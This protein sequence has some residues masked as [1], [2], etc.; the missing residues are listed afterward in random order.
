MSTSGK[1]RI[2]VLHIGNIANY[3]YNIAKLLQTDQI[4]SDAISWDY[5]HINS[6]PIWEE[7]DFDASNAGDQFFPLLP[8][9]QDAGFDQPDWYWHGPRKLAMLGLIAANEGRRGLSQIIRRQCERHLRRIADPVYRAS[10]HSD[11]KAAA[12]LASDLLGG[13]GSPKTPRYA[14]RWL[15]T[16]RWGHPLASI[17][18]RIA[19]FGEARASRR[20]TIS[21]VSAS[22]TERADALLERFK[23]DWPERS[24]DPML[25]YQYQGDLDVMERLFSHYDIVIGYALDGIWP[26]MAKRPYVAYEFGTIRNLPFED[27]LMGRL[28]SVVYRNCESTIVT[29]CDNEAPAK[30]LERPYR[31]LPHVINETGRVD[32]ADDIRNRLVGEH[33]GEFYIFHPPRHHWD[34]ERNTNWD[35]GNDKL[36]H[37]FQQLVQKHGIDAR[38]V[39]VNWGATLDKSKALAEE[40]GVAD[41][42]I[43]ID[44]QPHR[45]MMRYIAACDVVADQFT[46]PTF[47]GIPPK[48]F[49]AKRPVVTCFDPDLH[50]WCFDEL[51]PLIAA[52]SPSEIEAA[53]LQ[54]ATDQNFARQVAE[55]AAEWYRKENSNER[56]REILVE[57]VEDAVERHPNRNADS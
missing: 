29:N 6:R 15:R 4:H 56:I 32:S 33:G 50:R 9:P 30:R 21:E 45:R 19:Q 54:L 3:A 49:F 1:Q 44:P 42:I 10:D 18:D 43:W 38:C 27:S 23:S 52:S 55:D 35:K 22:F 26:L 20:F 12:V 25:L 28:A 17:S 40:L 24:I 34:D 8:R 48:A 47:G 11:V 16:R 37:A 57:I 46:I 2:K 36:I 7:G 39:F 31:F 14:S 5:Y 13:F 53:L 51:P 41:K